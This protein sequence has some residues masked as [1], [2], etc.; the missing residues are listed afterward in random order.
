MSC[1]DTADDRRGTQQI[2]F[3]SFTRNGEALLDVAG[4]DTLP[5]AIPSALQE[6]QYQ[7]APDPDFIFTS[8]RF[9]F[10]ISR[11]TERKCVCVNQFLQVRQ[12]DNCYT[13]S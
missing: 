7:S 6:L 2:L 13:T 5:F 4:P 12:N 3:K 11:Q 9:L 8:E 1:C 10:H